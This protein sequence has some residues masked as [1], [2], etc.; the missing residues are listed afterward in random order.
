MLAYLAARA[1]AELVLSACRD[2]V[3][4]SLNLVKSFFM[5]NL[6]Y[7]GAGGRWWAF[8]PAAFCVCRCCGLT[9]VLG[10]LS[11]GMLL[12]AN[13]PLAVC[14][15]RSSQACKGE[16]CVAACTRLED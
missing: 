16:V 8:A 12:L 10:P 14:L 5:I 11:G 6:G 9:S 3:L 2:S 1:Q 15:M 4:N 7:S 13:T